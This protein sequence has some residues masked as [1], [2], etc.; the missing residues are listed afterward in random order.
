MRRGCSFT[1]NIANGHKPTWAPSWPCG[2]PNLA[3]V[4]ADDVLTG[5]VPAPGTC[6][7]S[8]T[9]EDQAAERGAS[10][11]GRPRRSVPAT[12]RSSAARLPM[13]GR[14]L[15]RGIF[16]LIASVSRLTQPPELGEP[17]RQSTRTQTTTR[18]DSTWHKST[19]RRLSLS[20]ACLRTYRR[21]CTLSQVA[22]RH[23]HSA[24]RAALNRQ[25]GRL[26]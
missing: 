14:F 10:H 12:A 5:K 3:R 25:G 11:C 23:R 21:A 2:S 17:P 7:H 15:R 6:T 24:S 22:L 1:P 4:N 9:R 18:A 19:Y 26:P 20:C 13:L 8:G 16:P